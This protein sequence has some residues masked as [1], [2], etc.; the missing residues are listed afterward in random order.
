M[1][2]SLVKNGASLPRATYT[3]AVAERIT[4][5]RRSHSAQRHRAAIPHLS[6]S[7]TL[8]TAAMQEKLM[9]VGHA[10]AFHSE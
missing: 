8:Q 2:V 4:L 3:M 6:S 7:T 9:R 1:I 10:V 5:A